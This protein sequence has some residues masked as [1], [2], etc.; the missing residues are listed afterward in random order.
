MVDVE[1]INPAPSLLDDGDVEL[2]PGPVKW[3]ELGNQPSDEIPWRRWVILHVEQRY[4][5]NG[6]WDTYCRRFGNV[7]VIQGKYYRNGILITNPW[8]LWLPVPQ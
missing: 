4:G 2:H 5:E 7:V 1:D 3:S 8:D 6:W